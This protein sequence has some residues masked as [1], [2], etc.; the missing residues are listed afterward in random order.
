MDTHASP[1]VLLALALACSLASH[2][3]RA[4]PISRCAT[5]DGVA[6]YT[7]GSCSAI[8]G[9]PA[10]MSMALRRGLALAGGGVSNVSAPANHPNPSLGGDS[11][12]ATG[13]GRAP[14][15]A[16]CPRTEGELQAA[17]EQSLASGDVNRLA[18]VYDWTNVSS[19][20]SRDLLQ[21]LER[22]SRSRLQDASFAG[23]ARRR[24]GCLLL[25]L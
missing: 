8:G 14:A 22:M 6:T 11:G 19:R 10:P 17:F 13:S 23:T 21:R 1:A 4:A 5:A 9:R 18:A 2:A 3:A 24:A 16:G 12:F 25:S 7:D 20:Q 15:F